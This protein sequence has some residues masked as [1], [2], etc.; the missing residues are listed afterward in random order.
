[1]AHTDQNLTLSSVEQIFERLKVAH[2]GLNE[3]QKIAKE[4]SSQLILGEESFHKHMR[5]FSEAKIRVDIIHQLVQSKA[6]V[7]EQRIKRL[8]SLAQQF[9]HK[10]TALARS[11]GDENI[12]NA[13]VELPSHESKCAPVPTQE[14]LHDY[15]KQS[16]KT[17]INANRVILRALTVPYDYNSEFSQSLERAPRPMEMTSTHTGFDIIVPEP[18]FWGSQSGIRDV[19]N[20]CIDLDASIRQQLQRQLAETTRR[21]EMIIPIRSIS[22]ITQPKKSEQKQQDPVP[23]FKDVQISAYTNSH[24]IGA[25]YPIQNETLKDQGQKDIQRK[26]IKSELQPLNQVQETEI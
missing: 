14:L 24:I 8:F 5:N 2:D 22:Q 25:D 7:V 13:L 6:A 3:Q 17:I 10:T 20:A 18:E 4:I 11:I 12:Y 26:Q 1:M 9:E 16:L 15:K 23:A 19:R 21:L